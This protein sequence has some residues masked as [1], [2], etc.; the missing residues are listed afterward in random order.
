MISHK[1]VDTA[2]PLNSML[3][4]V[5]KVSI[6]ISL[7]H[8]KGCAPSVLLDSSFI[9]V[10]SENKEVFVFHHQ[11]AKV[12]SLYGLLLVSSLMVEHSSLTITSFFHTTF[13]EEV[14]FILAHC[15]IDFLGYWS[16]GYSCWHNQYPRPSFVF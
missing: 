6:G 10:S 13:H 15:Q 4:H 2:A 14:I 8:S 16:L 12:Q 7:S 11:E 9:V 3:N 1:I 5:Y